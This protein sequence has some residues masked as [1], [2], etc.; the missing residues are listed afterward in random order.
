MRIVSC[1]CRICRSI[2]LVYIYICVLWE[3]MTCHLP[4]V[5]SQKSV[6]GTLLTTVNMYEYSIRVNLPEMSGV[7]S[8]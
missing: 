1:V 5:Y 4:G 8:K 2:Y 7:T 6:L 3:P